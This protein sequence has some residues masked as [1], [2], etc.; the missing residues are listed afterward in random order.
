MPATAR[1]MLLL[2][3]TLAMTSLAAAAP[4]S[5]A[6]QVAQMRRG[7]SI[8][9]Y[10]PLWQDASKARFQPR[11]FRTLHD[12]G[13]TSVR[14]VLM[15]FR[16]MNDHNELPASWFATLDGLVSEALAQHLTVIIDE[17]DY[18]ACGRDAVACRPKLM[19]FWKQVAAHYK[20]APD[21]VVFEILNEPNGA[22]NDVWNDL[23]AEALAII[24]TTNPR[25]NVIIGPGFWNNVEWLDKLVLPKHDRHIIVTVHYYLPMTFTHQGASW[26]A[27]YSN[28]SGITWGTPEQ[29]AAIDHDF[30][31]VQAWAKQNHRPIL[32]GEFGAY[33]KGPME[34]RVKYTA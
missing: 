20:D 33:D 27:E 13:F 15:A 32:L 25:R 23:H 12:G 2:A 29:Y 24:R 11:Y 30:D 4:L 31:R 22:A 10:D 28:L 14:M 16:F 34:S 18:N 21:K 17:H 26:T 8:V 7:V 6:G 3:A 5:A 9:G 19:A 1:R